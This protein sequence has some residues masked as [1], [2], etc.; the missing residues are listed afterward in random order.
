MSDSHSQLFRLT[1]T[2]LVL[3][4]LLITMLL[5][6]CGWH[7]RGSIDLPP[8]MVKTYVK[9]TARYSDLGVVIQNVFTG[10]ADARQVS[11]IMQA[12]A[13]LHILTDKYSRRVLSTDSRGR[14][15]EYELN[16]VLGFKVTDKQGG[17]IAREQQVSLTREFRFNPDNVL[18]NDVEEQ[19][20]RTDLIRLS[21]QNMFRRINA[22]LRHQSSGG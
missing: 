2:V 3:F 6:S 20:L 14:A 4:T 7:L 21:V 19:Q 5:Q 12:T 17:T 9:G 15:T 22:G 8:E 18:S 11:D 10:Q 1:R 13:I 16:Y